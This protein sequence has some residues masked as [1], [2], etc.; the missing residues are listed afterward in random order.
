VAP[1]DPWL[2]MAAAV[3]RSADEREPW[4]LAE[5]LTAAQALEASTDGQPTIG[6]RSRGD[7]VLLDDD[8]LREVGDSAA[9]AEHL[10]RVR[11]AATF[12]AGR[13]THLTV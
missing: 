12:L 5:A 4:N 2:A 6:I 9:V 11:V 3:H 10:M 13:P 8:P 7:V 1:L